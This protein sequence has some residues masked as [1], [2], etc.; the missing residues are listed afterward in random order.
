MVSVECFFANVSVKTYKIPRH[1]RRTRSFPPMVCLET[2]KLP[3]SAKN[4]SLIHYYIAKF[5]QP[6]KLPIGLIN[7]ETIRGRKAFEIPISVMQVVETPPYEGADL[8]ISF[9]WMEA[10]AALKIL[11]TADLSSW[12]RPLAWTLNVI[13]PGDAK[14]K[15]KALPWERTLQESVANYADSDEVEVVEKG[16]VFWSRV[17]YSDGFTFLHLLRLSLH[18]SRSF[19]WRSAALFFLVVSRCMRTLAQSR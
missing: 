14:Y 8:L 3:L 9:R 18:C 7:Y 12:M 2:N 4:K 19:L 5:V 16:Q 11:Y 6:R 10:R 1:P 13:E 17:S 15:Q